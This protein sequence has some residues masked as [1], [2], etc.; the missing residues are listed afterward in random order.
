MGKF[1]TYHCH[2]INLVKILQELA[3]SKPKSYPKPQRERWTKLTYLTNN[4]ITDDKP[5]EQ[6]FPTQVATQLPLL[7]Q[8]S[9]THRR[10][11]IKQKIKSFK[12]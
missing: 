4:K 12:N 2:Q 9:W 3:E 10:V 5:S 7:N 8:I 6:P 11:K 1:V